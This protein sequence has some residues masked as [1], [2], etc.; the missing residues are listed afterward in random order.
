MLSSFP[1]SAELIKNVRDHSVRV[2]HADRAQASRPF[3]VQTDSYPIVVLSYRGRIVDLL[4]VAH[5]FGHAVQSL[6]SG[7]GFVPPVN[8]EIC[9]FLSELALLKMLRSELPALH[10]LAST[11]WEAGN[12]NYLGR[13][14]RVLALALRDPQARY[15]YSWNYPV[16]RVLASQCSEHLPTG[17]L[18]SIFENRISLSGIV[19]FLDCSQRNSRSCTGACLSL[20]PEINYETYVHK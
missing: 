16:A 20:A 19:S 6:A 14:G 8:R 18:W 3:T 12:R 4:T 13:H 2:F 5:E 17:A 11:A 7:R 1:Q 10:R 9:A 15:H